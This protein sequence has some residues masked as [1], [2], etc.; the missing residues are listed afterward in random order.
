MDVLGRRGGGRSRESAWWCK[1]EASAMAMGERWRGK[2]EK[3]R[4][5]P[6]PDGNEEYVHGV[7]MAWGRQAGEQ[8]VWRPRAVGEGGRRLATARWAGPTG[9]LLM[10]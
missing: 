2:G 6:E 9:P 8:V 1:L 5:P 10:G 7:N 3:G 4:G